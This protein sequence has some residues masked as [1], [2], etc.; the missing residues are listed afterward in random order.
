MEIKAELDRCIVEKSGPLKLF[1]TEKIHPQ[2]IPNDSPE[3]LSLKTSSVSANLID[4]NSKAGEPHEFSELMQRP[5]FPVTTLRA[6]VVDFSATNFVDVVGV[7]NLKDLVKECNK[8]TVALHVSGCSRRF[9]ES[10]GDGL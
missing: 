3:E 9:P 5:P 6:I 7:Q 4:Q 1:V 2:I 10:F 8:R